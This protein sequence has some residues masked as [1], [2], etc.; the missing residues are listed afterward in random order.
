MTLESLDRACRILARA[1][2]A[3]RITPTPNRLVWILR[4]A[5]FNIDNADVRDAI[6]AHSRI[7]P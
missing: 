1:L 2:A 3:I 7:R 4:W 5:G 6:I